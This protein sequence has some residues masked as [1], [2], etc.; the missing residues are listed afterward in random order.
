MSIW[1]GFYQEL[2]AL[3]TLG[4]RR[5]RR[6]VSPPL[7][8]HPQLDGRSVLAFCS[9]D[10]LGLAQHTEIAAAARVATYSHGV[11]AGA[12]HLI[13]GHTDYHEAL[14]DALASF[15]ELPAALT[16][17][18]GYMANIGVVTALVGRGDAVFADKLNHA[19]LNDAMVLSRAELKR[20]AHNDL[21]AL[22]K[23]LATTSAKRRLIIT[24]SVFSMDGDIARLPEL[25][26]LAERFDALLLVDDAHGFG[27][28]GPQGQGALAHFGLQ[29]ERLILMGTLGK[30]AGVGG[31]FVAGDEVLIDWLV[32]RARTYIYTTATPPLLAAALLTSLQLIGEGDALRAHLQA[33]IQRLHQQTRDLPWAW[34]P[35]S[36]PIQPLVVGESPAAVALSQALLERDIWVPAIRPPTV[37]AGTAR[38]R[39]SL[40]AAHTFDDIDQLS[41]ALNEIAVQA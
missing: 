31:A 2:E 37:P 20:Y 5:R 26:A 9:N 28:L 40:S 41:S 1:Y 6:V 27:V 39:V 19:S 8:T 35:S 33:L 23:A 30:A 18:T 36:T 16:F 24:D 15:V 38:L 3:D 17:S 22:E 10:Y 4:Q 32:N 13:S 21:A 34:M 29:S 12:A 11:G 7:G 25:L 14:E